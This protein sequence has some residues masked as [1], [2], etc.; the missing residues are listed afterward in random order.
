MASK[1]RLLALVIR[2]L[3]LV[4][5]KLQKLLFDLDNRMDRGFDPDR[6]RARVLRSARRHDMMSAPDEDYYA[7]Q[8][9]TLI[10]AN[11]DRLGCNGTGAYLDLGCGQGRLSIPLATWCAGRQGQVVGIDHSELAVEQARR[12]AT[13][14]GVRNLTFEVSDIGTFLRTVED[15]SIDGILLTEVLYFLPNPLSVLTECVRALKRGGVLVVSVRPQYFLALFLLQEGTFEAI[16]MLLRE[17][18]G[19]LLGDDLWLNWTIAD[20]IR[21]QMTG[22]L[23]LDVVDVCGIGLCTGIEGDPHAQIARPSSLRAEDRATLMRLELAL[24]RTVPDAARYILAVGQKRAPSPGAPVLE[25][26]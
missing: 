21:A 25:A 3:I 13:A 18:S 17:R 10:R 15:A 24:G 8:Y 19:R 16:P 14:A 2:T 26:S 4:T 22:E 7:E 1:D 9:W 5:R 11:L 20:E 12:H 6:H 23:D